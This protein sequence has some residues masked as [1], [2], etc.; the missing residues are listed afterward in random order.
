[1]DPEPVPA[2]TAGAD[3]HARS[4]AS[5]AS[6][7]FGFD[8]FLSFALGSPPR[9]TMSYASDLA[10][11]LRERDFSVFFSEQEAPPGE[12]LD[13]VLRTALHRS[14]TQ[15]V[16]ANRGTLREP[17]W[18]RKEVEEFRQYHPNRLV[19]IINVDRALQDP[20]LAESAQEW[21]NY[22]DKIWLDESADAVA[23]G[24]ASGSL[25]ERL[26]MAPTRLKANVKWRWAVRAIIATLAALAI[27]LAYATKIA[28]DNAKEAILQR[29]DKETARGGRGEPESGSRKR[30]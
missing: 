6:R 5:F 10:R 30:T 2:V 4:K 28:R 23:T 9:G 11:D 24:I 7:L 8:I 21:L 12:E 29:N 17:R 22:Q 3:R 20:A 18:V 26:S 27:G 13:I 16:I 1:M 15:V 19:V 14:K 25:V